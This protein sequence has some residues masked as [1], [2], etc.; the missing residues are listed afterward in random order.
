MRTRLYVCACV[1]RVVQP[2]SVCVGVFVLC[3]VVLFLLLFA[4]CVLVFCVFVTVSR[5]PEHPSA[6]TRTH[7]HTHRHDASETFTVRKRQRETYRKSVVCA[8]IRC[9]CVCCVWGVLWH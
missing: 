5:T 6:H 3:C 8:G 9:E 7:A 2:V 1:L 4:R